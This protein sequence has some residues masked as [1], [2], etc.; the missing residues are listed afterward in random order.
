MK[1]KLLHQSEGQRI[2]AAVFDT[3]DEVM[4]GIKDFADREKLTGA[5]ITGLGA[6]SDVLLLY[7]D[8][9]TKEYREIPVEEQ[10]E[11]ASLVGD[12]G[13]GPEDEPAIHVHLVVGCRNGSAMAGHLGR[14]HVR[15]TLELIVSETPDYLRRRKDLE[16][17]LNLIRLQ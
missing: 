13:V 11:V 10:V 2:F 3:G 12:I 5:Q 1:T 8:W 17:G 14:A 16:T 7:F 6:L 15:P 9:E 4:S